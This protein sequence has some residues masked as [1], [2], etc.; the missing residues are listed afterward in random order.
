MNELVNRIIR[1][2]RFLRFNAMAGSTMDSE[3]VA[4]DLI[5]DT[6]ALAALLSVEVDPEEE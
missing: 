3:E 5:A 1:A 4:T 2:A 6:I